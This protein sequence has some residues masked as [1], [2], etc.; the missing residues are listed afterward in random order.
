MG[1]LPLTINADGI[2]I[3]G[4]SINSVSPGGTI[5]YAPEGGTGALQN[6]APQMQLMLQALRD[7]RYDRFSAETHYSP[8]G[9][10]L[11]QMR[12][13]GKSPHID[14]N[15]P[16]HLNINLEQNILSLLKSLRYTDGLNKAL[17]KRVRDHF[18]RLSQ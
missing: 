1:R 12:L 11:L 14:N 13:E 15:R 9:N 10:L 17:D 5:H 4:G 6:T 2:S 7:F 18:K 16:I 8:D 3:S